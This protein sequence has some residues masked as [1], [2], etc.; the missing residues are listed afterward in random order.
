MFVCFF[1]FLQNAVENNN[2]R[3]TGWGALHHRRDQKAPSPGVHPVAAQVQREPVVRAPPAATAAEARGAVLQPGGPGGDRAPLPPQRLVQ[4]AAAPAD[5]QR[6]GLPQ[7]H[8]GQPLLLR[9][10]QLLLHP[11]PHGP[12]LGSGPESRPSLGLW[13]EKPQQG[14]GA[15]PVLLLLQAAPHHAAH[16]AARLPGPAAPVQAPE[17]AEGQTVPLHVCGRGRPRETVKDLEALIRILSRAETLR[18]SLAK[19]GLAST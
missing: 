8:R 1:V 4:D 7:P 6:G 19:H 5:H 16:S 9:P 13:E 2:P 15:V 14:P 11:P 3:H 18:T 17:G 12:Q 10:V